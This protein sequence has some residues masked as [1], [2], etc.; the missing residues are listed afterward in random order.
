LI[1]KLLVY[2]VLLKKIKIM[3]DNIFPATIAGFTQYIEIAYAKAQNSLQKYGVP[4]DKLEVITPL[5]DDYINAEA[6][7]ANTETAIRGA[8]RTRDEAR[9]ALEKAWRKFLNENIR[10]N[11]AVPAA[12]LEVF[13]IKERDT[14]PT[15]IGIPDV[16]PTLSIKQVGRR[17][18]ELEVLDGTTGK[19][20]KPKF[21]TGSYIY[22]AVTEV[23]VEP[24]H[25]SEY[26]KMDFSS[27]CHHVLEFPIEHV[28]KQANIYASYSNSHGKE[29]P[30][31]PVETV[32][33]G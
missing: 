18:Y 25:E 31:G 4:P 14:T 23:G 2:I 5:Y 20:K 16:I 1:K 7:A 27:N 8:R 13:G 17:R 19:K 3:P 30:E 6:V 11:S 21:A 26:H 33:I 22:L 32:I 28:A 12:D 10:Y 24:K 15:K 29:G 9:E